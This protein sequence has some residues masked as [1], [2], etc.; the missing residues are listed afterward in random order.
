MFSEPQTG[1]FV[2]PADLEGHLLVVRPIEQVWGVV[3]DFTGPEGKDGIV[4]DLCDLDGDDG[5]TVYKGC[6]WLSSKLIG[7]LKRSCGQLVLGTMG[8]G[9]KKGSG[10]PPWILYAVATDSKDYKRAAAWVQ[11][12]PDFATTPIPE[13]KAKPEPAADPEPAKPVQP[14]EQPVHNPAEA[15][16]VT[17]TPEAQDALAQLKAQSEAISDDDLAAAVALM[18]RMKAGKS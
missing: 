18:Q 17:L 8:K 6:V 4:V 11:A 1:D 15:N 5:P 2:K 3:T 12:N 10:L 14:T 9:A 7:S 13:P 16:G